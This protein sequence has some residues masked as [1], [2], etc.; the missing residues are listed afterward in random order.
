MDQERLEIR[1]DGS[2]FPH[3]AKMA[4]NL[5]IL[6]VAELVFHFWMGTATPL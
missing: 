2:A 4:G 3:S 6:H 1:E 5:G